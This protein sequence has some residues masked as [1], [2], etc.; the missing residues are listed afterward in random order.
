MKALSIRQPFAELIL[1]GKK[2]I[3]YR[4]W[5]TEFRGRFYVHAPMVIE[6][7]AAALEKFDASK[8][9]TG[10]IIG[11]ATLWKVLH[12]RKQNVDYNYGFLLKDPKRLKKPIP[13][14]GQQRFFDVVKP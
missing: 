13:Y 1:S 11:K 12:L 3:E 9:V 8:L 14:T 7:E 10:A 5:N 2:K 6:R 4:N